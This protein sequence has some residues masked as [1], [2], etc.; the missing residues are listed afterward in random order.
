MAYLR[1][2]NGDTAL[3]LRVTQTFN[4]TSSLVEGSQASTQVSGIAGVCR[5]LSETSGN[6]TKSL[7]PSGCGVSHHRHIVTHVSEV[8]GQCDTCMVNKTL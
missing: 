3:S 2:H 1:A 5:H 8:L 4:A 7:S 6:L